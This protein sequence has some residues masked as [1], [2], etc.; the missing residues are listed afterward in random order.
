MIQIW[1][2]PLTPR[3]LALVEQRMVPFWSPTYPPLDNECCDNEC[4]DNECSDNECSDN[5]YSG[6]QEERKIRSEKK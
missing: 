3:L 1:S 2:F 5:E 4:S 6:L